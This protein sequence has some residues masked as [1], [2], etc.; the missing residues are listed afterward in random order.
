MILVAG[1]QFVIVTRIQA[2]HSCRQGDLF[3]DRLVGLWR[4]M[5][6]INVIA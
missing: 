5:H 4:H 2:S 1:A 3:G 6:G